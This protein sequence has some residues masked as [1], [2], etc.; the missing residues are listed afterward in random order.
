MSNTAYFITDNL[1]F[2]ASAI[3]DGRVGIKKV[4][5]HPNK[6]GVKN[7]YL[8]PFDLANQVYLDYISDRIK[9]SP[10]Q[11][12]AKISEIKHLRAERNLNV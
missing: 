6:Q 1:S 10:A 5:F 2:V 12:S 11:L 7:Y 8:S 4:V 9:V 3:L